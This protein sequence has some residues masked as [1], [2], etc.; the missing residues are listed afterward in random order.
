MLTQKLCSS[1]NPLPQRRPLPWGQAHHKHAKS[2]TWH[3]VSNFPLKLALPRAPVHLYS[4]HLFNRSLVS[5][6][7]APVVGPRV[8]ASHDLFLFLFSFLPSNRTLLLTPSQA[9]CC[10]CCSCG[11]CCLRRLCCC[12]RHVAVQTTSCRWWRCCSRK[13]SR[14]CG[15]RNRYALLGC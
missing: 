14:H 13:C 10:L 4:R 8:T 15:P 9:L 1:S 6:T 2:A 11:S 5:R 12:C 3:L 7:A